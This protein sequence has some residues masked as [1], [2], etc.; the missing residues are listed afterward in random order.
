M[1]ESSL[2]IT[3]C[4]EAQMVGVTSELSTGEEVEVPEVAPEEVV[5]LEVVASAQIQ[6]LELTSKEM[7]RAQP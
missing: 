3:A 4:V 7:V 6:A 1:L 5:A 2:A